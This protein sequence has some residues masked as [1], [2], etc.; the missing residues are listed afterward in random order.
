MHT[1][2]LNICSIN[3]TNEH[4]IK[5]DNKYDNKARNMLSR[6][7]MTKQAKKYDYNNVYPP[8]PYYT[9]ENKKFLSCKHG[10]NQ[11]CFLVSPH[12]HNSTESYI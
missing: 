7:G 10:H 12:S 4:L 8:P 3:F 1:H 6:M 9:I 11:T 5:T 2:F